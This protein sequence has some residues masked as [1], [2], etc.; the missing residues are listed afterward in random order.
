LE[1][2]LSILHLNHARDGWPSDHQSGERSCCPRYP[3]DH[4]M[5]TN[6]PQVGCAPCHRVQ[7]GSASPLPL[8]WNHPTDQGVFPTLWHPDQPSAGWRPPWAAQRFQTA[9][10][11][12]WGA[13]AASS[14]ERFHALLRRSTPNLAEIWLSEWRGGGHSVAY[15][16]V[17]GARPDRPQTSTK[18]SSKLSI[19]A[20]HSA[21]TIRISDKLQ[22]TR[23][24]DGPTD[25][26]FGSSQRIHGRTDHV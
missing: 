22:A 6:L 18:H 25:L 9:F 24:T 21:Y 12:E 13:V 5:E 11:A 19:G 14:P 20:V 17:G 26:S 2:R 16:L 7:K 15:F 3:H 23:L 1:T 4:F 8:P 10:L